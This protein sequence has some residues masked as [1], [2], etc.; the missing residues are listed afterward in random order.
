MEIVIVAAIVVLALAYLVRRFYRGF[1]ADAAST[2]GGGCGGCA[3]VSD[4]AE[5]GTC[6][7]IDSNRLS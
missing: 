4:C 5:A 6:S 3:A 1:K 7:G 2:C